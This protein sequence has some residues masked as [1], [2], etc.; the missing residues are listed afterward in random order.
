LVIVLFLAVFGLQGLAPYWFEVEPAL[1]VSDKG[2]VS[3]RLTATYDLLFTQRLILQPRFEFNAALS[4]TQQFGVAKG[5]N[6]VQLGLRLRYEI[7][8][9]F[10][11]YIGLSW[12]RQF[13]ATADLARAAGETASNVSLIAG[14]RWW[15]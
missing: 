6:D 13:A 2:D 15:F 1:F 8:R 11:P 7:S 4:Q 5:L 14:L 12:Q 3:A 10:A 9:E